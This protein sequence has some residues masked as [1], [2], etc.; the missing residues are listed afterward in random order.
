VPEPLPEFRLAIIGGCM[1]HQRGTPPSALYHRRLARLLEADPGIRL[2]VQI[3]RDFESGL[4]GRLARVEPG[5]VDGVLVHLR[6][7]GLIRM[8]RIV[9]RVWVDGRSHLELNPVLA[10]WRRGQ[11][12]HVSSGVEE[13]RQGP[14][15]PVRDAALDPTDRQDQAPPGRRIAGFRLR[16]LNVGLAAMAGLDRIAVRRLIREFD[17]FAA[18][19]ARRD[20]PV[21]VLGPTPAPFA[22][23]T[24]RLVRDAETAIRARLAG[25][26]TPFVLLEREVDAEG[27]PL[28]RADLSHLTPEG[29]RF[30]GEMLYRGGIGDWMSA[31]LADRQ[32]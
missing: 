5:S 17:A 11:T 23:W 20:M 7:F 18:A 3:V 1:S 15:G 19:A 30:V 13:P 32:P 8:V 31:I 9:R 16:D 2:R 14:G 24:R 22:I 25:G 26:A 12:F 29:Q 4:V 28:T 21:F 10:P 27:R 6:S